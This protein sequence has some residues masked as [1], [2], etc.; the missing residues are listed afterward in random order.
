MGNE[1][2]P[3]VIR[4]D[5]KDV[6]PKYIQGYAVLNTRDSAAF[7]D[8]SE[9]GFIRMA[10]REGIR[11]FRIPLYAKQSFYPYIQLK[12]LKDGRRIPPVDVPEEEPNAE[13]VERG[14]RK[15]EPD[16]ID[17]V[18]CIDERQA[19]RYLAQ[20]SHTFARYAKE[21]GLKRKE[22]G[23]IVY[24]PLAQLIAWKRNEPIPDVEW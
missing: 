21:K 15:V 11:K 3:Q 24:Y 16:M 1:E 6:E 22:K 8:M 12:A 18:V 23:G 17:G 19:M 9:A 4:I 13:G 10:A 2:E 20:P 7:V 5:N 14:E